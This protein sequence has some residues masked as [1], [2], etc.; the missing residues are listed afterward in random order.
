MIFL[1]VKPITEIVITALSAGLVV[2]LGN[3]IFY[4]YIKSSLEKNLETYKI[5]YSGIFKEKIEIHKELLKRVYSFKSK[6]QKY[7][8][9]GAYD[10]DNQMIIELFKESDDFINYY[11]IN[12][13]FLKPSILELIEKLNKEYQECFEIFHDYIIYRT[14]GVDSKLL[15]SSAL[16]AV[17]ASHRLRS[18][19]FKDIE[20]EIIKAMREDLKNT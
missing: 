5:A 15:A 6:L 18:A 2:L 16:K 13:P 4:V 12:Q 11:R 8:I 17:E 19:D 14:P 3:I 9:Y 10:N 1:E 7:G 20:D